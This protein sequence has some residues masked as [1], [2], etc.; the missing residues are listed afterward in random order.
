MDELRNM[1]VYLLVTATMQNLVLTAGFGS[2]TLAHIVRRPRYRRTYSQLLLCFTVATTALFYPLDRLLPFDWQFRMLR[3]LI[4][5]ALT[6]LL[7][8]AVVLVAIRRFPHWY[9]HVRRLLPL[10]AFNNVV[11]GA[12]LVT[13]HQLAV[14]FFPA[15]GI[16]IGA[17]LGFM[18]IS[19]LSAEALERMDNPDTPAAFRG[20]PG[21]LVYLGLFALALMGF[22]SVLNLI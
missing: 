3:P 12:A 2:S 16:A 5:V 11:V 21:M 4:V 1:I 14:S 20:L 15:I 9:R 22:D 18:L 10:T 7:Y 13:N 19:A 17:A 6:A 8:I